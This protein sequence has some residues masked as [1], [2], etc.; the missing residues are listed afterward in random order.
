MTFEQMLEQV[1]CEGAYGA[2][3]EGAVRAAL[4][5]VGR[6]LTETEEERVHLAARLPRQ[7]AAIFTS[8]IP[9]TEPLIG[10]SFVKGLASRTRG[11]PANTRWDTGTVL[12][13]VAQLVGK[14][15]LSRILTQPPS[16]YGLLFGHAEL[17]QAA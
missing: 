13:I 16:S 5:A 15:L 17:T 14:G 12:R 4:A 3:A 2:Q 7:A 9:A 11:C 8:Q 6:Q 10:W 1:R